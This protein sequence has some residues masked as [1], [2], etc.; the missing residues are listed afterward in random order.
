M[1][2]SP[3]QDPRWEPLPAAPCSCH[4]TSPLP[5][6]VLEQPAAGRSPAFLPGA[7]EHHQP[8]HF[9]EKA[10][11]TPAGTV[12]WPQKPSPAGKS[13]IHRASV[14]PAAG[15]HPSAQTPSVAAGG[16]HPPFTQGTH[17]VT[18]SVT[19]WCPVSPGSRPWAG[20]L[21]TA[22]PAPREKE[23]PWICPHAQ[24]LMITQ[25]G[26]WTGM[27]GEP[28]WGPPACPPQVIQPRCIC[29]TS[30]KPARSRG[31][32]GFSSHEEERHK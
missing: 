18:A 1:A 11:V 29:R 25:A 8:R 5:L 21:P 24:T 6:T 9:A 4:P 26:R 15:T 17:G 2:P 22:P 10:T 3:C 13:R 20:A 30:S 12:Q 23:R 14:P 31:P 28:P 27:S 16:R 32:D 7:R 19:H